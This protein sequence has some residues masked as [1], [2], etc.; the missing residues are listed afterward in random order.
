MLFMPALARATPTW[1]SAINLS[2]PGQDGFDPQVAVNSNGD[3]LVVWNRSDGS[4]LRIQAQFRATD[5]TFSPIE[6][7]SASNRDASQPQVAFDPSGNAIAVWTQSDGANGRIHAAFRP[8]GGTFGGDQTISDAGQNASRP[9][10]SFDGSG[11]AVAV[12]Y[13][14]DGANDRVQAAIR[15]PSGSFGPPQTLSPPGLES[16]NPEVAAGPNVDANGVSIWTGSDGVNTR[17]QTAR[18]RDVVGFPRP[19]GATPMR[20][21]LVP[22]FNQCTSGN[23]THGAPLAF[24]SCA[25]PQ[26]TSSVLTVGTP[27]ANGSPANFTGFVLFNAVAGNSSTEA[28]E[29]DVKVQVAITDVRNR[30][31]LTDYVGRVLMRA[32]LQITDNANAPETPEPGTVQTFKYSAPVDCVSTP[33][34]SVG[35]NCNLT[36]TANTLVPGTVIESRR[37]IWQLGQVEVMDA[38]PNGTGYANCPPTCGDGDEATF[39][40]EGIFAP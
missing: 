14:F 25:P 5:G 33:S 27:D 11:N 36:T 12:W 37:S 19:R 26:Q 8:A 40:R 20:V 30:P 9:Q 13:R 28:N 10:I 32:D 34:T 39:L 6:T 21:S 29:A 15:P 4:K 16:F 1:L 22:A 24:A 7:I 2:D 18:R 23:R 35:S 31:S 3:S 38:G 17:V